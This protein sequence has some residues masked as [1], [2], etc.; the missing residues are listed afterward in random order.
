[1]PASPSRRPPG[2]AVRALALAALLLL[3]GC[4]SGLMALEGVNAATGIAKNVFELDVSWR[5]NA[6]AALGGKSAR[7]P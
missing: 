4:S 5:A 1:M 7:A 6:P 2:E 3:G